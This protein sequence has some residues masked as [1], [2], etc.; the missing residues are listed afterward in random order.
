MSVVAEYMAWAI[1]FYTKYIEKLGSSTFTSTRV[2]SGGLTMN[3]PTSLMD[4]YLE[5][6]AIYKYTMDPIFT[7]AFVWQPYYLMMCTIYDWA[8]NGFTFDVMTNTC[9]SSIWADITLNGGNKPSGIYGYLDIYT[10]KGWGIAYA[11]SLLFYTVRYVSFN[12]SL[13]ILFTMIY[14]A[15]DDYPFCVEGDIDL[16]GLDLCSTLYWV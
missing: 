4:K 6:E 5:Y 13:F 2:A 11:Y 3:D 8:Q 15:F 12:L 14:S 16:F 9:Y 7:S 10:W 1:T